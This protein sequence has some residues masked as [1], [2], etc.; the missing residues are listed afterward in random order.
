MQNLFSDLLT[1]GSPNINKDMSLFGRFVGEWDFEW[2]GY[3]KDKPDRHVKGEWIFSYILEGN[4]VQ[5]MFI[6]PS[7]KE[8]I[9]NPQHDG[10]YGT[11]IRVP[12]WD[13][14]NIWYISYG[15]DN[16]GP[17][18][19]LIAKGVNG[20]IIQTGVNDD[21]GDTKIWQWNFTEIEQSSF[22]WQNRYSE[23]DG[24]TWIIVA[25]I[26]AKRRK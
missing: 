3:E 23:D 5:D 1:S 2:I 26:Y 6:C 22:H 20:D 15:C 18:C 16:G 19:R 14:P 17:T 25:D 7:R 10:E 24:K 21:S 4:A 9:I 8:R 13:D 11:T 12:K